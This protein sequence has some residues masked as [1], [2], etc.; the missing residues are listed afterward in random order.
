MLHV[1]LDVRVY[2]QFRL[3][4][5]TVLNLAGTLVAICDMCMGVF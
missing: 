2:K 1:Q 3:T 5:V 4:A